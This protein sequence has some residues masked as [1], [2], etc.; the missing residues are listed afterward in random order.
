M[1][2]IGLSQ[3]S[4]SWPRLEGTLGVVGVAPWATLEFCRQFLGLFPASKDWEYPRIILDLN[5]KIPS[6]GRFLELGETNPSPFIAATIQEMAVAGATVAVVPC[7][8]AH[9][10]Y[11]SWALNLDIPVINIVEATIRK[12]MQKGAKRTIVLSSKLTAS[13]RVYHQGLE[14]FQIEPVE[15]SPEIQQ[16]VDETIGLVKLGRAHSQQVYSATIEII[17]YVRS[18]NVNSVILGCTELGLLVEAFRMEG[19]STT[20]SLLALAEASQEAIRQSV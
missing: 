16:I 1:P 2:N 14:S 10:L 12:A 18:R 3:T 20:D 8:T 4:V 15:V 9:I 19:V 17:E 11:D 7:N 6:R 5:S 13:S